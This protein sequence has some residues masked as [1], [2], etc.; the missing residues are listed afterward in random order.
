LTAAR[1]GCGR[2]NQNP[3]RSTQYAA[4]SP[5]PVDATPAQISAAKF[6]Q[7]VIL[8]PTCRFL[9]SALPPH[10]TTALPTIVAEVSI[11]QTE[12]LLTNNAPRPF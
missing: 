7:S 9:I 11:N 5:N 3:A 8:S 10:I 12:Y 2:I 1:R 4:S 6:I